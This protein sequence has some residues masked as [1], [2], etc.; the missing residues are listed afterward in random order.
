M[1]VGMTWGNVIGTAEKKL[2]A[3]H[4]LAVRSTTPITWNSVKMMIDLIPI[5]LMIQ[6]LGYQYT[7]G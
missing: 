1:H 2:K 4:R 7:L 5:E 6:K 3:L